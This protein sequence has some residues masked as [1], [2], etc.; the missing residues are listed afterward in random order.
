MDLLDVVA[1][2]L[3]VTHTHSHSGTCMRF[4]LLQSELADQSITV[5]N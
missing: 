5:Q 3:D 4:W 2:D 1:S